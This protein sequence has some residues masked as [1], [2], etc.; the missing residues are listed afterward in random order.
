MNYVSRDM[1]SKLIRLKPSTI[2]VYRTKTQ[3][4]RLANGEREETLEMASFNIQYGTAHFHVQ[5]FVLKLP[6]I[7]LI[8]GLPWFKNAK[9][10]A[11][12][13]T[14]VYTVQQ[15]YGSADWETEIAPVSLEESDLC[16]ADKIT[17]NFCN[18]IEKIARSTAEEC[19]SNEI[20]KMERPWKHSIETGEAKPIKSHGRPHTPPEHLLIKQFIEEGLRDGII[21]PSTS[22]WSSPLLLVKKADGATRVCVDYRALNNVTKKNA[23]PLPRIDDAYQFL[24]GAS[25]FSTIDLKSGFWKN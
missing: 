3:G 12:Y 7:D 19:F 15:N 11:N 20:I 10:Q 9:P 16:A 24:S 8:L 4:V 6:N 14:N 23:Y 25:C 22:P 5:A 13:D 18:D 2:K 21:E 1:I 17:S